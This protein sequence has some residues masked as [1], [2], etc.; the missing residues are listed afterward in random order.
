V[1][2][3]EDISAAPALPLSRVR[4]IG[5]MAHIDAGKTTATERM[6]YYTGKVYRIGEVDEGTA[7]MDWMELE[8]ERGITISAAATTCFW[9][10]HRINIIDTPGHVDFTA[11]VERSLRVLDGAV[12]LYCAVGGVEPQSETVWHQAERYAIPRI[13]FVNKMDR[14]GADFFGT[15]AQMREKLM[16]PAV[17]VEIPWGAEDSFRGVIDLVREVALAYDADDLSFEPRESAIPASL[18]DEALR[19]REALLEALAEADDAILSA[20]LEGKKLSPAE[21]NAAIRRAVL[22]HKLVPVLCGAALRNQGIPPLLDAIVNYLPS[23]LDIPS[24]RVFDKDGEEEARPTDRKGPLTALVFKIFS[25]EHCHKL[26][27]IRVYSGTLK[28]GQAVLNASTGRKGRI[29]RILEMHAN[30]RT[31]REEISA[32]EIAVVVGLD[33]VSTGDTLCDPKHPALLMR[34]QFT[35]PVIALSVEPKS[36]AESEKLHEALGKLAEEDPTF[37][38]KADTE[39]GQTI[40]SGMGELHLQIMVERLWREFGVKARMGKPSVA[41]RETIEES[42]RGEGKFIRQ[43]GGRGHYGHVILE[44]EPGQRGSGVQIVNQVRGGEIPREFIPAVQA[45]VTESAQG[46]Y[47]NGYPMTDMIITIKGGSAHETD[48]SEFAFQAAAA[49]AFKDAVRK[50]SPALLEPIMDLQIVTPPEFMGPIISDL[51]ARRSKISRTEK[52]ANRVAIRSHT[53]LAELFGYA[54]DL[55]SMTQGRAGYTMEPAYFDIK[56]ASKG[57]E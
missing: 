36:P 48:S 30:R 22:S 1:I 5:I 44:V 21:I 55:R 56:A 25:D 29:G 43:S 45:G 32:G 19:R 31:E 49:I 12:A 53:P 10:D 26:V 50:A 24:V 46:G 7:T 17:P 54:T 8:Q 18:A 2:A 40:I 9:K 38:V 20:Y 14:P 39:T 28:R 52:L 11:E 51:N 37:R 57:Q 33:E 23:P 16:A 6:L 27:Y 42:K 13:A 47:I 4:N 34:M 35:E 41:Y 3:T 15:V